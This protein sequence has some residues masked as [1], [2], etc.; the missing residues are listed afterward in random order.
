MANTRLSMRKIN[1]ILRLCWGKGLS[2]RQVAASCGI[3]KTTTRE[4]LDRAK[5][6]GLTWPLPED[7]DETSLENL[8]SLQYP[9]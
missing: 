9:P 4:Y 1:E 3:G 8:L 7:L 6:A 2:E 5:K